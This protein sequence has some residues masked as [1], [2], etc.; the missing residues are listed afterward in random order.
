VIAPLLEEPVRLYCGPC[1]S[2]AI[3]RRPDTVIRNLPH[4]LAGARFAGLVRALVLA[5]SRCLGARPRRRS[6]QIWHGGSYVTARIEI[7]VRQIRCHR[8]DTGYL[9]LQR[10]R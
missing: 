3:T 9:K 2:R 6:T 1:P 8:S 10:R 5:P 4:A 7:N